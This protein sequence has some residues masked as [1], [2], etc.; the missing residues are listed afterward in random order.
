[1]NLFKNP[2]YLL[3]VSPRD[4]RQTIVEVCDI[5]SLEIDP[6]ICSEA[7]TTLIT[8]RS[9]LAAEIAWLPG[10]SPARAV[11]LIH[12]INSAP[13]EVAN[14]L[15]G[16]EPLARCN[17]AAGI[18]A[19]T[20]FKDYPDNLAKWILYLANS[21]EEVD[22]DS[23]IDLINE[24]REISLFPS[25]QDASAI[26][27][28]MSK[29]RRHLITV[30]KGALDKIADR[31][32]IMT[33]IVHEATSGGEDQSP[34]LIEELTD[35]YQIGVQRYL[36]QVAEEINLTIS[37]IKSNPLQGI[38]KN[39]DSI[40]KELRTLDQNSKPIQIIMKTKGME[41]EYALSIARDVRGLSLYLANEQGL[42]E[43]SLR[44]T[45]LM[46][47]IFKELP[48]FANQLATDKVVLEGIINSN[49]DRVPCGDGNCIGTLNENGV[50]GICG[51]P[52]KDTIVDRRVEIQER[53]EN[54]H[55]KGVAKKVMIAL[56]VIFV[57][58]YIAF[59][60]QEKSSTSYSPVIQVEPA[61]T[62]RST[63]S[64]SGST[65]KEKLK[66]LKSVISAHKA[67]LS[68]ME[69]ELRDLE[70][71]IENMGQKL[72]SLKSEIDQRQDIGMNSSDLVLEHNR[73]VPVFN[74]KLQ[75]FENLFAEYNRL[76]NEINAI[77]KEHNDLIRR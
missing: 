20:D 27:E 75:K 71:E 73:N 53:G 8:P 30:M 70:Y 11:E 41:D 58:I 34:I 21:F 65:K 12:K 42:Y 10:T 4:T 9:R 22:E 32:V 43:E 1:M 57:I 54:K 17:L 64:L 18:L 46:I 47:D 36:N 33:K 63:P 59:S 6:D 7:K 77:I 5:K 60:N 48:Q 72:K 13:Q 38:V 67:K 16:L 37:D 51:K 56:A 2:F 24:D 66:N 15:R 26:S 23:I 35:Q 74:A 28:E 45:N 69:S 52:L 76:L 49:K 50:C 3:G 40:E 39:V 61:P 44:L 25:I 55:R 14:G 31:N 62:T 29:H 19:T 68:N